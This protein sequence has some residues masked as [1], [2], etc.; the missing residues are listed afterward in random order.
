MEFKTISLEDIEFGD[1]PRL[2]FMDDSLE[3]LSASLKRDGL[4]EPIIVKPNGLKYELIIGERRV[5]AAI[6][7]N[8]PKLPAIIRDDIT[9]EEASRFAAQ[10]E[11]FEK[12]T[13]EEK[14]ILDDFITFLK[15]EFQHE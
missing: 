3:E 1:N 8:I 15:K 11:S 4:I 9:D 2:T 7:A 14:K 10:S 13:Q 6:R 5:R 12:L